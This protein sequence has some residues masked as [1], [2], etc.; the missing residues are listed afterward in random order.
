MNKNKV[1]IVEDEPETVKYVSANLRARGYEVVAARDGRSALRMFNES[2]PDLLILDISLPDM[3]GFQICQIVR[4]ESN[5]PIV[6]LSARWQEQEIV[7]ALDMGA[8]DYLTKPFGVD[9]LLARVRLAL[10][11]GPSQTAP[12]L[13]ALTIQEMSIDF[14]AR[15]V[16]MR[17]RSVNLTRIEF[18]LLA[19]L[20]QNAGRILTHRTL[21]QAVW[22][23]EYS[24][25][26]EYL[27]TYIKRLRHKIEPDPHNPRYILTHTGVG[28]S[29]VQCT[30]V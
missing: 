25:E 10:R 1:L 15:T 7:R 2:T 24:N 12:F 28:Y 5:V 6:V 23:P 17:E 3:D 19:Y 8:D 20:A 26:T 18:D 4:R 21:L 22:G 13:P 16:S 9:E 11:H 30:T 29:C 14:E 27:W